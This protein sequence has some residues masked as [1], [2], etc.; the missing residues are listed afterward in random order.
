M[1]LGEFEIP[2]FENSAIRLDQPSQYLIKKA[3]FKH[4]GYDSLKK[5]MKSCTL[6]IGKLSTD[7]TEEQLY[8]LFSKC[9]VI[10]QIIMGLDRFKNIPCGFCFI[11][12]QDTKSA[13]SAMKYLNHTMLDGSKIEIDLDPGFVEGRQFGRGVDGGQFKKEQFSSRG[14]TYRGG[15][16]GRGGYRY[17]NRDRYN[18]NHGSY[19]QDRRLKD[20]YVPPSSVPIPPH[21]S[22]L[23]DDFSSRPIAV[24]HSRRIL[25]PKTGT[26]PSR[27]I[28][29]D[30]QELPPHMLQDDDDEKMPD[31]DSNNEE[32]PPHLR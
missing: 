2:T 27:N 13:L 20:S 15:R 23:A 1:S 21:E 6:Y 26:L 28:G 12:Y 9:G 19:H 31:V 29:Q 8:E 17:N 11:I 24:P 7:T 16:G 10:K 14:G 3:K 18:N 32:L 25:E 22:S 30:K 5:S 4:D